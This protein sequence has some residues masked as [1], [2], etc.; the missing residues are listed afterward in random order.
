MIATVDVH[1][2]KGKSPLMVG[3]QS[4]TSSLARCYEGT[5]RKISYPLIKQLELQRN[6]V[7]KENNSVRSAADGIVHYIDKTTDD[8]KNLPF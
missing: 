7:Y 5:A 8:D 6:Y 1:F 2:E 4:T 3:M